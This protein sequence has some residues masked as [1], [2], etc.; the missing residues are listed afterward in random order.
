MKQLD[1][2]QLHLATLINEAL[3]N[4]IKNN[5]RIVNIRSDIQVL[6][7]I[8]LNLEKNKLKF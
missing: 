7:K 1:L 5:K 8:N 2:A 6:Q 3:L 4:M